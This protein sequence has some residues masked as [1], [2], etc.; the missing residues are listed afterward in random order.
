MTTSPL[1]MITGGNGFVGYA[2]IAGVLKAGVGFLDS[3]PQTLAHFKSF[4]SKLS[5][6]SFLVSCF[7]ID[8][9]HDYSTESVR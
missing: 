7:H 8:S 2:V 3:G 1:V 5:S 9:S 4:Y 6:S